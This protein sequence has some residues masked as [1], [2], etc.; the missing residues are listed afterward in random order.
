MPRHL[1][2]LLLCISM[3]S[4]PMP[5]ASSDPGWLLGSALTQRADLA[6]D[7]IELTAADRRLLAK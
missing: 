1:T 5:H 7:V 2:F 6:G 4:S 3:L